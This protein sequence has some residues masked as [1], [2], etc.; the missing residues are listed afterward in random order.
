MRWTTSLLLV[1][2]LAVQADAATDDAVASFVRQSLNVSTYKRADADLNGDGRAEAFI[3]VT[4]R[5][6]CGSGGCDLFLVSPAAN[7]FSVVL[8]ST[9]TQLPVSV[10]E[11][12]SNGWRDVGITVYGGGIAQPYMARLQFDGRS[13][14]GNPSVP[15][16][17]RMSQPSGKVVVAN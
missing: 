7:G 14:P 8:R 5:D 10:L 4:D 16:A 12:S 15:P 2:L 9:I 13:Y 3:Y 11:T 6:R 1:S 17:V